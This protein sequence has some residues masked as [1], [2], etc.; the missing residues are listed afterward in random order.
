MFI[1]PH[2]S[3][4]I[5][6]AA[7]AKF[8]PGVKFGEV[9]KGNDFECAFSG[10]TFNVKDQLKEA[11]FRFDGREKVWYLPGGYAAMRA[12]LGVQESK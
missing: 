10:S 1:T 4:K 7:A 12:L 2:G 9:V 3:E 5:Q 11:G 8:G 6:Q